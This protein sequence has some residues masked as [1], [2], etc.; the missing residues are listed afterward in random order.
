MIGRAG[1]RFDRALCALPTMRRCRFGATS[2]AVL[3]CA[4]PA[5]CAL[6]S[7]LVRR[8]LDRAP[9]PAKP[10]S[11]C[12]WPTRPALAGRHH[13]AIRGRPRF[14]RHRRHG[15]RPGQRRKEQDHR[16][17]GRPRLHP[18]SQAGRYPHHRPLPRGAQQGLRHGLR[19]H[20]SFEL[21][22]PSRDRFIVGRNEIDQPSQNKLE[23]LRPQHFLDAL[24]VRPDRP[25][26]RQGPARKPH[27]RGQRLLH[28]A[29]GPRRRPA[30]NCSSRAPSG[31]TA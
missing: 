31:S 10:R 22:I 12:W 17:Q 4:L 19:R 28:P 16:I 21:Y 7:C 8:R 6:S 5:R 15:A 3:C 30:A 9:A 1:S 18:L 20:P 27:R 11:R 29:R 13:P 26:R 14:Q 2:A 23:N 24:L 25:K